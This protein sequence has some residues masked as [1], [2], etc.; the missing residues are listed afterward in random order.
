MQGLLNFN[1]T[2]SCKWICRGKPGGVSLVGVTQK[3]SPMMNMH[4]QLKLR[5]IYWTK[6]TNLQPL[7]KGWGFCHP[8]CEIKDAWVHELKRIHLTL[9]TDQQC[10][11]H[12]FAPETPNDHALYVNIKR[13]LCGGYVNNA[14][15]EGI[16]GYNQSSGGDYFSDSKYTW[17]H[18]SLKPVNHYF[19]FNI[20][21][22]EQDL[23]KKIGYDF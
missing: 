18:L 17:T 7:L 4:S 1:I 9:L 20:S 15:V 11:D 23:T 10:S 21:K 6:L 13:E 3:T 12:G 16:F 5:F 14:S 19:R 8:A 2:V 22:S